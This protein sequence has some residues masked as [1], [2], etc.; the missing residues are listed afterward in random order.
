MNKEVFARNA[1]KAFVFFMVAA[2][3]LLGAWLVSMRYEMKKNAETIREMV[4]SKEIDLR[5]KYE[6]KRRN[7][8]LR[9]ENSMMSSQRPLTQMMDYRDKA[10]E[11]SNV[12]DPG[13]IMLLKPGMDTVVTCAVIAGGTAHE[14]FVKVRI[15]RMDGSSEDVDPSVLR[16]LNP[17]RP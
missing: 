10:S 14:H 1:R 6:L 8:S 13:T 16:A 12:P 11:W 15:R 17:E 2:V 4:N 5:E 9:V 3:C 7:D